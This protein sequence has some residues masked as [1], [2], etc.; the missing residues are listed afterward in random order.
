M[1]RIILVLTLLFKLKLVPAEILGSLYAQ[2]I[3]SENV[4]TSKSIHAFG[5]G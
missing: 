4:K 2:E 3:V 5:M 1:F